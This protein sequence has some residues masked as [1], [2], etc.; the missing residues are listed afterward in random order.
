MLS[1]L[2]ENVNSIKK[3]QSERKDTLFEIK[4]NLQGINSTVDE[5]ENQVSDVEYKEAKK[6]HSEKQ[7]EKN[8]KK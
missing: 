8:P 1:E 2:S 5:A 6:N 7:E 3:I 4:N